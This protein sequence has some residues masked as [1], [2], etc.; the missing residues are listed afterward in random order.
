MVIDTSA[1]FAILCGEAEAN[2]FTAAIEGDPIR[3]ISDVTL[4]EWRVV[5]ESRKGEA[6]IRELALLLYKSH[7]DIVPYTEEQAE[8][9]H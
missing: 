4:A 9:A 3:L 7:I 1:I 6:G 2:K 8:V 5:I